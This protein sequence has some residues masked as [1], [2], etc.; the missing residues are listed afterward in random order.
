MRVPRIGELRHRL[1]FEV[2]TRL[3]D[4][5]GGASASWTS[6]ETVWG[7]VR[8]TTGSEALAS[9]GLRGRTTHE[10]WIRHRQDVSPAGRFV[11]GARTFDIVAVL[12]PDGGR[13]WLRCLAAERGA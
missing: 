2:E 5:G 7:A 4:G 8:A 12:D 3:P 1:R 6:V 10:I 13:R 11:M 9:D